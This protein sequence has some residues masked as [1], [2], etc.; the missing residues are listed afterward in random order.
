LCKHRWWNTKEKKNL[1]QKKNF[2]IKLITE[3]LVVALAASYKN[4]EEA[5]V[6][7]PLIEEVE[8]VEEEVVAEAVVVVEAVQ[9][10]FDGTIHRATMSE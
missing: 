7:R 3:A 5:V 9:L 6:V 8:A 2:Q 4:F 10:T 1:F